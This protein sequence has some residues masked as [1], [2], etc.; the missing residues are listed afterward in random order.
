MTSEAEQH[1]TIRVIFLAATLVISMVGMSVASAGGAAAIAD[2]SDP[3]IDHLDTTGA[4]IVIADDDGLDEGEIKYTLDRPYQGQN[5]L[6]TGD[7]INDGDQ[8]DLY[9]VDSEDDDRVESATF[10]EELNAGP[11]QG[12]LVEI[13]TDDIEAGDYFLRHAVN[14][15]ELPR[16]PSMDD[17][18]EVRNQNL[19]VEFEEDDLPALNDD[20]EDSEV[21]LEID[22]RRGSYATNVS[23]DGDLDDEELVQIFANE[24]LAVHMIDDD[25][26]QFVTVEE[27]DAKKELIIEDDIFDEE[28]GD[29]DVS[30]SDDFGID[31]RADYR[32]AVPFAPYA[33]AGDEDGDDV[34]FDE[35]VVLD[36]RGD[37]EDDID[38]ERIDTGVYLFDFDVIDTTASDSTGLY[39]LSDSEKTPIEYDFKIDNNGDVY[40]IGFPAPLNGTLADA[41]NADNQDIGAETTIYTFED[42][43]WESRDI[44]TVEPEALDAVVIATDGDDGENI[45][46]I[47]VELESTETPTPGAAPVT[48]GWNYVSASTFEDADE[49]FAVG[50]AREVFNPFNRAIPSNSYVS[51]ADENLSYRF[52]TDSSLGV[53]PFHG[54]FVY[55]E[56]DDEIQTALAGGGENIV[57]VDEYVNIELE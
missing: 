43:N 24:T 56:D 20:Y 28:I 38:F 5:V 2:T 33:F 12:G 39:V 57:V 16:R 36:T 34:D 22:S 14:D 6:A 25:I 49:V 55:V 29:D 30:L 35:K 19:D 27:V 9:E 10:V 1:R 31:D 18:F 7:A 54:Y 3:D 48:E 13:D 11:D 37:V 44:E 15:P 52:G 8:Y 47:T 4:D 23:A 17:T 26:R 42:G 53:S 45:I 32:D 51:P 40:T 21:E 46:D 41:M 50:N